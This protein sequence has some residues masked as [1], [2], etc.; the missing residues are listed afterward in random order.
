MTVMDTP[1]L[2]GP[3]VSGCSTLE[4]DVEGLAD[5]RAF[6][7]EDEDAR[8]EAAGGPCDAIRQSLHDVSSARIR[9][10][11]HQCDQRLKLAM[12][13][14]R[15][16]EERGQSP[17]SA[18]APMRSSR[19][20]RA[21]S[22]GSAA[23]WKLIRESNDIRVFRQR[24][25]GSAAG[26]AVMAL[27]TV[28]GS[29]GDVM[30][31]LYADTTRESRV[32]HALLNRR[33]VDAR[34]LRVDKRACD[35]RPF[36]FAG[37]TWTAVKMPGLGL[38][39]L[40]DFLCFKKMDC[41][42][43]DF[44]N[45]MGYVVLQ[46]IDP[47]D[48]YERTFGPSLSPHRAT[49]SAASQ[50][51]RYVR[52]HMSL[53]IVFKRVDDDRVSLFAHGE[54]SPNGRVPPLLSD[55]CIADALTSIANA[56][57]T[58]E[59]KNL[60]ALLHAPSLPLLQS[61]VAL[62]TKTTNTA[63]G[64]RPRCGVCARAFYFWD[65]PRA[66]RSCWTLTCRTC[67]VT[68]P[69]FCSHYQHL[70]DAAGAM[71]ATAGTSSVGSRACTET[72]CLPCVC[73]VT[74]NAGALVNAQLLAR[75]EKKRKRSPLTAG[76][77][78]TA[79]A[80]L[81]EGG[82]R[83]LSLTGSLPVLASADD[84][85]SSHMNGNRPTSSISVTSSRPESEKH[86]QMRLSLNPRPTKRRYDRPSYDNGNRNG[87]D[88]GEMLE[89]L[90]HTHYPHGMDHMLTM[91][92]DT[93]MSSLGA[94]SLVSFSSADLLT[95][96]PSTTYSNSNTLSLRRGSSSGIDALPFGGS[97]RR[98]TS[99]ISSGST[100]QQPAYHQ[101]HVGTGTGATLQRRRSMRQNQ[102]QQQQQALVALA[103]ALQRK[104][105]VT[106]DAS[107]NAKQRPRRRDRDRD[108]EN[109]ED[110]YQKMLGEMLRSTA[111]TRSLALMSASSFSGVDVA[112]QAT[113]RST[114]L[115]DQQQQIMTT[116]QSMG[117]RRSSRKMP[118][119]SRRRRARTGR[120]SGNY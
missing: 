82:S 19:G 35:Q 39:K 120:N 73:S 104:E 69:I 32:L 49:R 71:V 25:A 47:I 62:A 38:C 15:E 53:A 99:A 43:D 75:L 67:R 10:Y 114:S 86:Q 56:V 42:Q 68:R 13:L 98:L 72:F 59:A 22:V 102:Q 58:G 41:Y 108:D 26:R 96:T 34:V 87:G 117:G 46:S 21:A 52:G 20:R 5:V 12:R 27:G 4:M 64:G 66:C 57:R 3:L 93:D 8:A 70:H 23:Q 107:S 106:M 28:H 7:D 14:L 116:E 36:Q 97:F 51:T 1:P 115:A 50:S 33:F 45:D 101:Y 29:L 30:N 84:D 81:G 44:G 118:S 103:A 48:D 65:A 16:R 76:R 85:N 60:T 100:S 113:T 55:L 18:A 88:D 110:Y 105:S 94:A 83:S 6:V 37:V 91:R 90:E 17:A 79:A 74:P 78:S 11:H 111:S 80:L 119:Q 40:R 31:G 95:P 112:S 54:F 89:V 9:M 92:T 63:L 2:S 61:R 24:K 77:P 109:D